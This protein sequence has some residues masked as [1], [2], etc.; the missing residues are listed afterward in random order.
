MTEFVQRNKFLTACALV[1][2]LTP[3]YLCTMNPAVSVGDSG[4]FIAAAE[5]LSLPHAPSY[6]LFSI[7]GKCA[8][9]LNPF[10]NLAY[11]VN[12][13]SIFFGV[14]TAVLIFFLSI[15][16]SLSPFSAL[17][18][19]LTLFFSNVLW[20]HSLTAE[21]FTLN[22]FFAALILFCFTLDK[23]RYPVS[24]RT[25]LSAFLFGI[26]MGNHHTLVMVVPAVILL[27]FNE[28]R[29]I[30]SFQWHGCFLD[31]LLA[32]GFFVVGFSVYAFLPIR[33]LK[34]PPIDWSNPET[35][36]NFIRVITRA[37]YG[38]LSLT[39]GEKLPRNL[40]SA[41][42]QI[43]R[44]TSSLIQD[45]SIAGFLP[46][47]LGWIFWWKKNRFESVAF[48]IFFLI[49]GIGFLILGNLPFDSQSTGVLPR[50]Y[51]M[52]A[53]PLTLA[54]AHLLSG[55]DA[56]FGKLI[57][58]SILLPLFLFFHAHGHRTF[59]RNDF[60][61]YDYG[62]NLLH[63]LPRGAVLFMDGGDDTF[64][65]LAYLTMAEKRRADLEIHDRG[66]LI[67]RNPYGDDFRKI[68]KDVKEMR[69]QIVEG[70]FLG[71]RPLFYATFN[72][73]AL[74]KADLVQR[75]ILYRAYPKGMK[76]E[77]GT[78]KSLW[79]IYS[80]RGIYETLDRPYRLRAL[81]PL[82]PYLQALQMD[83]DLRYF[84]RAA[85]FGTDILWMQSNIP[86][87]LAMKAFVLTNQNK[88]AEAESI[89]H[90]I[91]DIDPN[92]A[93]AYS[94][95]GVLAEKRNDFLQAE[96]YYRKAMELD[97]NN[98][99]VYYNLGV[100]YWKQN[101]WQEVVSMFQKTLQLNPNHPSAG[102]YLYMAIQKVRK[103]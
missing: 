60:V 48:G 84:R 1:I 17:V 66:G 53:I 10:S 37:D 90:F 11:R 98:A 86:L 58:I 89:Y 54:F 2:F 39:L 29:G 97:P 72:R 55:L 23:K 65:T 35:L 69:R 26:G 99:E 71:V 52:S 46:A 32:L 30:E 36:E 25:A 93:N 33:S 50:F 88:T 40:Q 78:E 70:A 31:L 28:Q 64:Y 85:D 82:Y 19:A 12:L 94:N 63:T 76:P 24:V 49:S 77:D 13:V 41:V 75:G 34:N 43:Q 51:L 100:L 87:E 5:T 14:L 4:E 56:K 27:Y 57:W 47:F 67:Y 20:E 3:F 38:S 7:L 62:R 45:L 96:S 103:S 6:P 59:S 61:A 83:S 9:F 42:G 22:S 18:S 95:L 68:P 74:T 81:I 102:R 73:Q 91:V 16:L 15:Q 92:F 101:R 44:Y 21:V 79:E 8:V 80:E